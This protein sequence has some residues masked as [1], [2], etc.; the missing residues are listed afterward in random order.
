MHINEILDYVEK[1]PYSGFFYSA[2]ST[3]YENQKSFFFRNIK[4]VLKYEGGHIQDYFDILENEIANGHQC[5]SILP[6]ELGYFL[7]EYF[8]SYQTDSELISSLKRNLCFYFFDESEIFGLDADEIDFSD[9]SFRNTKIEKFR[10]SNL[11][12]EY[13]KNLKKIKFQIE[14]GNT[15]QVNYTLKGKFISR[16]KP[17]ELF[18]QLIFNQSAQYSSFI[19][20]S[21]KYILSISPEL[22]FTIEN[23]IITSRPM[24]GTI[25]RGKSLSEDNEKWRQLIDSEKD[26]AENLMIVDLIRNDLGNVGKTASVKVQRLFETEKYESIYQMTS[27][28]SSEL[29]NSIKF[30]EVLKAIF[31]CGSITGAPKFRTM[32]IIKNLE[33]KPRGI[34]TGSIG[35]MLKDKCTFNVAIRTIEIDKLSHKAEV[36]LGGG[37]VWDS[38]PNEEYNEV[39]LKSKFLTEQTEYFELF[40]SML[41]KNNQVFLLDSHLKRLKTASDYF[42]FCF[43]ESR[44][45]NSIIEHLRYLDYSKKYKMKLLLTKWGEVKIL[46]DEIVDF[47]GDVAVSISGRKINSQNRFQYFKTTNRKQYDDVLKMKKYSGSFDLLFFNE[48]GELCEGARSNVFIKKREMFYTPPLE[49][50]ILNG[51]ERERFIVKT[52]AKETKL[53]HK[54]LLEA[55]EIILTNSVRGILR[56][57]VVNFKTG[58]KN[59]ETAKE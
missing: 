48:R 49:S 38:N 50:G 36:G 40:E 51:I 6:Y 19:N 57:N 3:N 10:L 39:K 33:V 34:Y 55:E 4:K 56:V 11:K 47:L 25:A 22:F 24:K 18:K 23:D 59:L 27:T 43:N 21:D 9:F 12:S 54:D 53:Y 13:I 46:V 41:V 20:L 8:D 15:Y 30:S 42:L 32:D 14:E 2:T 35:V 44:I 37:I 16:Q 52:D 45:L 17:S 31:P 5:Y 1:H 26:K 58:N 7:D 29:K 28:I